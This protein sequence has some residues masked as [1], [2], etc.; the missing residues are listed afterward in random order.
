MKILSQNK[1][2]TKKIGISI[3][4]DGASVFNSTS[5]QREQVKSNL[6]NFILTEKGEQPY[7][8]QF[9][10]SLRKKLFEPMVDIENFKEEILTDISTYFNGQINILDIDIAIDDFNSIVAIGLEYS[11][12]Y[13]S[14][15]DIIALTFN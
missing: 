13:E 14:E 3:P 10:T 1:N 2:K 5:S 15:N 7:N 4:F 9:G 8:L 12:I 11:V 6:K